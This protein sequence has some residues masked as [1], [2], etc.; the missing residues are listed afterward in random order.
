MSWIT[1]FLVVFLAFFAVN[2]VGFLFKTYLQILVARR[3]RA[4]FEKMRAA[5]QWVGEEASR[6]LKDGDE[7]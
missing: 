3:K 6:G 4:Q 7:K 5:L 1:L 2:A